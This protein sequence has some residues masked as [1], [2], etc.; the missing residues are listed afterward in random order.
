[1]GYMTEGIIEIEIEEM[2]NTNS[3]W[4][5]RGGTKINVCDMGDRHL[6]NATALIERVAQSRHEETAIEAYN[7]ED[8]LNGEQAQYDVQAEIRNHEDAGWEAYVPAIYYDMLGEIRG[9][10]DRAL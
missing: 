6:R 10:A 3:L 2:S 7:F 4:T 8:S 9:R 1:M 5:Q